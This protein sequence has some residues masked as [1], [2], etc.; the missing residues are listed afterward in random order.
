MSNLLI[1]RGG[2]TVGP[3]TPDEVRRYLAKGNLA[4]Q[5]PAWTDGLLDWAPLEQVLPRA[6]SQTAQDGAEFTDT[7]RRSI[8]PDEA[9]GF[10]WGAFLCG[11]LWGF[12]YRVWVSILSWLPGIGA[13]VWL[14]MG[15]NG[16]EMAWRAREWPSVE[17]FLQAERRWMRVG[18][19][20]FW[21]MAL[22]PIGLALWA[23]THKGADTAT[24]TPT[25]PAGTE[26]PAAPAAPPRLT[27]AERPAGPAKPPVAEPTQ[28]AAPAAAGNLRPRADWR[29]QLMGR[30]VEQVRAALGEPAHTQRLPEKNVDVW[31]YRRLSYER[32][33]ADPDAYMLLGM[34]KGAVAGVE[35]VKKEDE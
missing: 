15:F 3:F 28:P 7:A 6:A 17:A 26:E 9:R 27:P 5:T 21:L 25:T 35:F 33:A 11:P 20:L 16:R 14:W 31:I 8:L 13:L 10:S 1:E 19:V 2:R 34:H 29:K 30:G 32:S 23:Y 4:P 12:P 24:T 22:L 18:L